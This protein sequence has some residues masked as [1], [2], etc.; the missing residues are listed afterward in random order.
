MTCSGAQKESKSEDRQGQGQGAGLGCD[1]DVG[2]YTRN[3]EKS[4]RPFKQV[5]RRG[6]FE[7]Q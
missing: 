2:H 5:E 6:S 1:K 4:L 3:K 7:A